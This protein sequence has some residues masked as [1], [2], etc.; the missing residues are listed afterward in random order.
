MKTEFNLRLLEQFSSA[1][2]HTKI[3]LLEISTI[4]NMSIGM[5][6]VKNNVEAVLVGGTAVVN[7]LSKG[8]DLTPDV[9]YLVSN[10][11][12]VKTKLTK[13][14]ILD[15]NVG[16]K[17]LNS[18]ILKSKIQTV[19]GGVSVDIIRPVHILFKI[20]IQWTLTSIEPTATAHIVYLN[21]TT[22]F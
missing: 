19:I 2:L 9:D 17:S 7:Y 21:S 5:E 4:D 18:L 22:T 15:P 3:S 8:R 10:I 1:N 12:D 11:N 6:W 16:N 20:C 13:D 14:N